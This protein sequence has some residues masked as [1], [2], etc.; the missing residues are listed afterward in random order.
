MTKRGIEDRPVARKP[1]TWPQTEVLTRQEFEILYGGARGGGKTDAGIAWLLYPIQIPRYRALVL[2]ENATDLSDWIDRAKS[3]YKIVGAEWKAGDKTFEF[4][5]GAKI[6]TGHL[7]TEDSYTKYQGHEYQR[8]L[9]EELTNIPSELLYQKVIGSCRS[10]VEGLKAQVLATTNPGGVGHMWVKKRFIAGRTPGVPFEADGRTRVFIPAK[11]EDNPVLMERDPDYVKYL[12]WLPEDLKKAWRDGSWDVFDSK[13]AYYNA[14]VQE[15]REQKRVCHGVYQPWRPCN[16]IFDI[17]VSDTMVAI[18]VQFIGKE[19]RIVD[20]VFGE[21]EGFRYYVNIMEAKGYNVAKYRLPHDARQRRALME[22][23]TAYGAFE[24]MGL[25]VDIVPSHRVENGIQIVRENFTRLWFEEST[26][27]A[28][29]NAL[30]MYRN[31]R[32][33]KNQVFT[34]PVH[35]RTSHY[36]D[37]LRYAVIV[38]TSIISQSSPKP[39]S[40]EPSPYINIYSNL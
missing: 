34:W 16:V 33:D 26:T 20:C 24:K 39:S 17:G 25:P 11:V 10:T 28:L 15:A 13:G 8:I 6:I 18:V 2:R 21:G 38:Y 4:P 36:A 31:K 40:Y 1:N 12:D 23:E 35:D 14:S 30:V 5:S 7:A 37:A 22:V 29:L 32:D 9:I 3:L 19:I 27:D